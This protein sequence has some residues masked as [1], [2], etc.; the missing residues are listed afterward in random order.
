[1]VSLSLFE[2]ALWLGERVGAAGLAVDVD[3]AIP[4]ARARAWEDVVVARWFGSDQP[5]VDIMGAVVDPGR[6]PTVSTAPW[7]EHPIVRAWRAEDLPLSSSM[8]SARWNRPFSTDSSDIAWPAMSACVSDSVLGEHGVRRAPIDRAARAMLCARTLELLGLGSVASVLDRMLSRLP[9]GGEL[10]HIGTTA[11]HT[12]S[13]ARLVFRL[14]VSGV[15]PW[16]DALAWSGDTRPLSAVLFGAAPPLRP[17]AVELEIDEGKIAPSV[18]IESRHFTHA[19]SSAALEAWRAG[20]AACGIEVPPSLLERASAL[21]G[22]QVVTARGSTA[23]SYLH[24]ATVT[25]GDS[26]RAKVC[27]GLRALG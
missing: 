22:T 24:F 5:R 11:P 19:V 7:T 18:G 12:A 2:G 14:P 21:V 15:R 9:E 16:L 4:G 17:I 8:L 26:W 23:R 25:D 1:M 27:V 20:A 10:L 3:R 6:L 13:V